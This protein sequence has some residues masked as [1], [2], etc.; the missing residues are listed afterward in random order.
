MTY[1]LTPRGLGIATERTPTPDNGN[2]ML[3]FDGAFADSVCVNSHFYPIVGRTAEIPTDTLLDENSVTAYDLA[4]GRRYVCDGILK[5][6]EG[7]FLVAAGAPEEERLISLS[8]ALSRAERRIEALEEE[9][10]SLRTLTSPTPFSFG[11]NE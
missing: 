3:T 4:A 9:V 8:L 1:Y 10:R 11:G 2:V 7:G 6:A 5:S